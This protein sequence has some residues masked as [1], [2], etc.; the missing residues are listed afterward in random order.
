MNLLG[1]EG[2]DVPTAVGFICC[3]NENVLVSME[4]QKHTKALHL[5]GVVRQAIAMVTGPLRD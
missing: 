2:L 5:H 1:K 3:Q 4:P